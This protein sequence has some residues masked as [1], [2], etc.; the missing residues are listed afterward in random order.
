MPPCVR[1]R[2]TASDVQVV[3]ALRSGLDCM[4]LPES[5]LVNQGQGRPHSYIFHTSLHFSVGLPLAFDAARTH[6]LASRALLKFQSSLQPLALGR[7]QS[8]V[9]CIWT[10]S[11][12]SSVSA[13]LDW[14][15][16]VWHDTSISLGTPKFLLA[17]KATFREAIFERLARSPLKQGCPRLRWSAGRVLAAERFKVQSCSLF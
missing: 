13:C 1:V 4:C 8:K 3:T 15:I 7:Q 5:Q 14:T 16:C 17:T 11:P 9:A 12:A 10:A 6:S 2:R